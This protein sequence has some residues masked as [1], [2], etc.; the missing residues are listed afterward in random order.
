M[1]HSWEQTWLDVAAAVSKRSRCLN[2]QVGAVIVDAHN[3]PISTGY[4]GPPAGYK[5][6]TPTVEDPDYTCDTFCSRRN[7]KASDS[8]YGLTCP[9]VHA[10][11]NAL[12]FADRKSFEG[13]KIYITD[14]P[15]EECAKLIAN[16]GLSAVVYRKTPRMSN[17][18]V[19]ATCSFLE[20]C[21]ILVTE[22]EN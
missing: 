10:E 16:S 20:T 5:P 8:R 11:A 17:Q 18:N 19:A 7:A 2:R 6:P 9:T 3:R 4:N 14:F 21:G 15:C 1:R 22:Y 13:G 12:L